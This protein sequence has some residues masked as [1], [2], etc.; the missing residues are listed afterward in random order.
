MALAR[1]ARQPP[2][3]VAEAIAR[4]FRASRPWSASRWPDQDSSTCSSRP[5]VRAW[6][7]GTVLAAGRVRLRRDEAGARVSPRVRVREPHRAARH[8]ERAGGRRRGRARA[9]PPGPRRRGGTRVLHQRRRP[10]V[11]RARAVVRDPVPP[12]PRA[13]RSICRT[14]RTRASTSWSWPGTTWR[15]TR[16]ARGL[17][18]VRPRA[19]RSSGWDDPR[20]RIVADQRRVL[21]EYG[22]RF[23]SGVTRRSTS[24]GGGCPSRR[25]RRWRRLDSRFQQD[26]ALWFRRPRSATTGIGSCEVRRRADLF[27]GGHRVPSLPQVRRG[28]PRDRFLGPDH[29]GYVGRSARPWGPRSSRRTFRRRL[30]QLVTLFREGQPY[31]CPSGGANSC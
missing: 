8:R 12:G 26:G 21:A 6:A 7:P 4:I 13:R 31:A 29:H 5:L 19:E 18:L 16:P 2:R 28:R 30:V 9:Y 14:A 25:S 24:G 17:T 23:D 20:W 11:P 22:T 15:K 10:P 27:R 1:Q 3:K